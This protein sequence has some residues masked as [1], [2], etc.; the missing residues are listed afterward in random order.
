MFFKGAYTHARTPECIIN[1][2]VVS[3]ARQGLNVSTTKM[4]VFIESDYLDSFKQFFL[5]KNEKIKILQSF[6]IHITQ[7]R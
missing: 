4:N 1:T 2:N 5:Q 6:I 7:L 3:V